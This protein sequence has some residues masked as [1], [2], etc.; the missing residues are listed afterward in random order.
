MRSALKLM[1]C[2]GNMAYFIKKPWVLMNY[3]E[4]NEEHPWKHSVSC[5]CEACNSY[6]IEQTMI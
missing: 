1:N 6:F 5:D 4:E 3:F 2:R